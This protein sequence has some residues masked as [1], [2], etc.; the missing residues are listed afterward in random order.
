MRAFQHIEFAC[1]SHTVI[2]CTCERC[3]APVPCIAWHRCDD[4]REV[5]R[6]RSRIAGCCGPCGSPPIRHDGPPQDKEGFV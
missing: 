3:G 2:W 6:V 4:V 1:H 5:P